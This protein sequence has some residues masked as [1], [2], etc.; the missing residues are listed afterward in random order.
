MTSKERAALK[1]QANSLDALFQVGK[2]GISDALIEQVE[3]AFTT[4]ELIKL[5]V[6]LETAPDSPKNIAAQIADA[7][8][9]EIVQVIGGAMVFYKYNPELHE[10]KSVPYEKAV[11]EKVVL[12]KKKPAPKKP[13]IANRPNSKKK[14]QFTIKDSKELKRGRE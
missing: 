9:A 11:T 8:G 6:L 4:R 7:T 3:T 10:G 5:K 1:A 14:G 13:G 12:K 2:G